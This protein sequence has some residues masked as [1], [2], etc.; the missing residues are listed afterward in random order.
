MTTNFDEHD[1]PVFSVFSV[2]YDYWQI[3]LGF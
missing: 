2:E 3:K 1:C